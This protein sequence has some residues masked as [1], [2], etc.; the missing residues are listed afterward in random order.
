VEN[1]D[2]AETALTTTNKLLESS[3]KRT[4]NQVLDRISKELRHALQKRDAFVF[5]VYYCKVLME[6]TTDIA[7]VAKHQVPIHPP[8]PD[9]EDEGVKLETRLKAIQDDFQ[10]KMLA[11]ILMSEL[12]NI[13]RE[14]SFADHEEPSVLYRLHHDSSYTFYDEDI[15]FCCNR[16][17]QQRQFGKPSGQ[18]FEHHV[19]GEHYV[20]GTP[21][22]FES[23]YNSL[24]E[25]P[26][27]VL[28]LA[29]GNEN[30]DPIVF[31]IDAVKLRETK[32]CIDR[33]RV[34]AHEFQIDKWLRYVN[35]SYWLAQYWV[36]ANC[37]IKQLRLED[38][39]NI[40]TDNKIVDGM[41]R[42]LPIFKANLKPLT[43]TNADD[44]SCLHKRLDIE[45]LQE[46]KPRSPKLPKRQHIGFVE[47]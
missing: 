3:R 2:T 15:G 18:D 31:V 19:K 35:D 36:P 44:I 7:E 12:V 16:W 11:Q 24:T 6:P 42:Y 9:A 8:R 33:A 28:R 22:H 23:P 27:H 20:K 47:E 34:L 14:G 43:I 10:N 41:L 17:L 45:T 37:I 29:K 30:R 13:R 38:F 5:C 46:Q 26:Y 39:R 32:I 40:S 1:E 25:S 21:A 4:E